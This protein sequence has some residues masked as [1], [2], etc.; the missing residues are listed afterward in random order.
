MRWAF[1]VE[2]MR[3]EKRLK[4]LVGKTESEAPFRI[5]MC[6]FVIEIT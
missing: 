6:T 5:P 2:G 1:H 4:M 3:N